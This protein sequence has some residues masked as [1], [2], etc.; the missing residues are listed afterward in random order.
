M[1]ENKL[2]F[3]VCQF[4]VYDVNTDF[5][6]AKLTILYDKFSSGQEHFVSHYLCDYLCDLD[7][8]DENAT[9]LIHAI[10]SDWQF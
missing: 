1:I 9:N 4:G 6:T 3:G 10:Q 8:S 2:F 5:F 7:D